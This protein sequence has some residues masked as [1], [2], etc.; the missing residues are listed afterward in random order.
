MI[1]HALQEVSELQSGN[2]DPHVVTNVAG[3]VVT[4]EDKILSL[5]RQDGRLN[6]KVLAASLGLTQRQ[7][8]RILT[9]LKAETKII[10]HG[11]SKNGDWEVMD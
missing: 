6:A 3:N 2:G 4:N 7:V 11:T 1:Y 9:K 5:L 10:R 8:Q